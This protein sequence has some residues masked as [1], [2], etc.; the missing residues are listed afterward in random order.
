MAAT[1]IDVAAND[2]EL[3]GTMPALTCSLPGEVRPMAKVCPEEAWSDSGLLANSSPTVP[4]ILGRARSDDVLCSSSRRPSVSSSP[5][6][7]GGPVLDATST[8][9]WPAPASVFQSVSSMAG[10]APS[11]ERV[12]S[13]ASDV[14]A[15]A[16]EAVGRVITSVVAPAPEP[17]VTFLCPVCYEN[18][19]VKNRRLFTACGDDSHAVCTEC[20]R[21][22]LKGRIDDARVE[23]LYCPIGVSRG[24]CGALGSAALATI[25]EVESALAD[26]PEVVKKLHLFKQQKADSSLR[27]C[28]SCGKLCKP[29]MVDDQIKAEMV[30]SGENGCGATFCYYHSWAHREDGTCE[31]YEARLVRETR[32]HASSFG[33]KPCPNCQFQTEKNGG[34]N[35]MT[36]YNCKCDWCW[37]CGEKIEGDVGFHYSLMNPASGCDQFADSATHPDANEVRRQRHMM[38]LVHTRYQFLFC[39]IKFVMWEITAFFL[40]VQTVVTGILLLP[41]LLVFVPWYK[42]KSR[43]GDPGP[44]FRAYTWTCLVLVFIPVFTCFLASVAA[45]TLVWSPCAFL[46]WLRTGCGRAGGP[47]FRWLLFIHVGHVLGRTFRRGFDHRP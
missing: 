41:A 12:V 11:L 25:E 4:A 40:F 39:P 33:T 42:L 18:V 13:A 3:P 22:Y 28:P 29:D 47:R 1:P 8:A 10:S 44:C 27:E 6:I 46:I 23:E 31:S 43:V 21:L 14:A 30:C 45:L 26:E 19:A 7:L 16:Q 35:H 17:E 36:C 15:G 37:I 32:A 20:M 9:A 24:S 5:A 38:N 2:A 34:C